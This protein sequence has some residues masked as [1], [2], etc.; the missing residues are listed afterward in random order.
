M[1]DLRTVLTLMSV[2]CFTLPVSAYGDDLKSGFA[3]VNGTKLYYE[4]KGKGP[5]SRF[6]PL[7]RF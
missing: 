2:G 1:L 7:G 5:A 6:Y 4:M 3:E